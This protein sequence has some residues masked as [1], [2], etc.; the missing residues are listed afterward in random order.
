MNKRERG[1][2]HEIINAR[3]ME[4]RNMSE[5]LN[6]GKMQMKLKVVVECWTLKKRNERR[7]QR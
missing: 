3:W 1:D 6:D 2:V 7:L 4:W 5:V